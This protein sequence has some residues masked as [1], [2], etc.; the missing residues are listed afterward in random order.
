MSVVSTTIDRGF[1][2]KPPFGLGAV[3]DRGFQKMEAAQT[4]VTGPEIDAFIE[5]RPSVAGR[6]SRNQV[7]SAILDERKNPMGSIG[8]FK[9]SVRQR[10]G[11]ALE[12]VTRADVG[13]QLAG[14]LQ[15]GFWEGESAIAQAMA[16]FADFNFHPE[17]AEEMRQSSERML[18]Y[19]AKTQLGQVAARGGAVVGTGRLAVNIAPSAFAL[20]TSGGSS[21]PIL[22]YY[23]IQ[24]FGSGAQ[25]Y[26]ETMIARGLTPDA[27]DAFTV[28][29]GYGVIEIVA[30]KIGLDAMGKKVGPKLAKALGDKFLR[31]KAGQVTNILLQAEL[32]SQIEGVEELLTQFFQNAIAKKGIPFVV[33]G[34][35]PNRSL[36]ENLVSSY[37]LGN[38]GGKMLIGPA[39]LAGS[40]Q[41]PT[42]TVEEIEGL[43]PKDGPKITVLPPQRPPGAP[44]V[45]RPRVQATPSIK[46]ALKGMN[47]QDR[48]TSAEAALDVVTDPTAS[49]EAQAR[50]L[51]IIEE[52]DRREPK[53][54]EEDEGAAAAAAQAGEEAGEVAPTEAAE[55]ALTPVTFVGFQ[56]GLG[57]VPGFNMVNEPSGTTVKFDPAKHTVTGVD[58]AADEGTVVPK[59]LQPEPL[60]PEVSEPLTKEQQDVFDQDVESR[61]QQEIRLEEERKKDKADIA[62]TKPLFDEEPTDG[63]TPTQAKD[64]A[65]EEG[66]QE[67][68]AKAGRPKDS[69]IR[70]AFQKQLGI[71]GKRTV[72]RTPVEQ[73]ML[74]LSLATQAEVVKTFLPKIRAEVK[75]AEIAKRDIRQST[76][77]L[78]RRVVR[79]VVSTSRQGT[80]LRIV[81]NATPRQIVT[82]MD[83]IELA[84]VRD[85]FSAKANEI[86]K[87]T[88]SI[89]KAKIRND[90]K[91]NINALLSAATNAI[92]TKK[93]RR[94]DFK[95]GK[96]K[97]IPDQTE[98][99]K[100]AMKVAE[101][102]IEEAAT[103]LADRKAENLA[104]LKSRFKNRNIAVVALVQNILGRGRKQK[105]PPS[106]GLQEDNETSIFGKFKHGLA[107]VRNLAR[108]IETKADDTSILEQLMWRSM[109][110][111][112]EAHLSNVRDKLEQ[113]QQ[114]A[115]NAGLV[116]LGNAQ[117]K[118]SGH[119]GKGL[120]EE[121][122]VVIGGVSTKLTMG[123]ALWFVAIDQE[124]EALLIAGAPLQLARGKQ[125]EGVVMTE[126]ELQ[127][128]RDALPE[129]LVEF[130]EE[131]KRIHDQ[132]T[133][134]LM[135]TLFDL[136]GRQPRRVPNYFRRR[137]NLPFTEKAGLP[138]TFQGIVLQYLENL[139]FTRE[140]E[141]GIGAPI[142]I[143]DFLFSIT[144]QIQ[145]TSKVI[146]I[147]KPVRAAAGVLLDPRTVEAINATKGAGTE[148]NEAL[149]THLAGSSLALTKRG[150]L[151]RAVRFLNTNLAVG[152]LGLNP[153]SILRQLGGIPRL[154]AEIGEE[155][156]RDGIAGWM[157][158]TMEEMV[159]KSGYF[160]ERYIANPS[161]RF[162]GIEDTGEFGLD[163]A[164]LKLTMDRAAANFAAGDVKGAYFAL[165][166]AG[167]STLHILNFFDSINARI[168]WAGYKAEVERDHPDWNKARQDAWV[169]EHA[170]DAIRETQNSSSVLD[171]STVAVRARGEL[172]S[173]W[174][175]FSSDRIKT[176]NRI[177]RA[178]GKSAGDAAA[179]ISAEAMNMIWSVAVGRGTTLTVAMFMA[180]AMGDDDDR[181]EALKEA[182]RVDRLIGRFSSEA[183]AILDPLIAPRLFDML[184][185]HR[186]NLFD[187]AVGSSINDLA[188][189]AVDLGNSV[190]SLAEGDPDKAL[191]QALRGG[192]KIGME[193]LA[194]AG[195]DPLDAIM[196]RIF[197][198]YDDL[199]D[200]EKDGLI[201]TR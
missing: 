54:V 41:Q 171:L 4:K 101:P 117:A 21:A 68:A 97:S 66:R 190:I 149:Q 91:A 32:V 197:R 53:D 103:I 150:N 63:I 200:G 176:H 198:E 27:A 42:T 81:E 37:L 18:E 5:K 69:D 114:A 163:T 201:L 38:A 138:A 88:K 85:D 43:P 139:G 104:V 19:N 192:R 70:K 10:L 172:M 121:I 87:L 191:E 20:L 48:A 95:R 59:E 74:E 84:I 99:F 161:G 8:A 119:A 157:N 9:P 30:E 129:E 164:G 35:D 60:T 61:L 173:L 156:I 165:R 67:P 44:P 56:E 184:L 185:Y 128:V 141:G 50:A 153:S 160:W 100:A 130:V 49:P 58:P 177:R 111:A 196:Q 28:G 123:E 148:M 135:E 151:A 152:K 93:G 98:K 108:K 31:N 133:D 78:I 33:E 154:A 36:D 94:R 126:Q 170:A 194:L 182:V 124:T 110:R 12:D 147:A 199:S 55:A 193:A 71:S 159:S 40:R 116:S 77:R 120:L 7:R 23:G 142:I 137:R 109:T 127:D 162:S 2:Q 143:E 65:A 83:K 178:V 158:I 26:R 75:A 1:V 17:F 102:G 186:A 169:A 134:A 166:D 82:I 3:L 62:P 6:L 167:I 145:E 187:N 144:D 140:R 89:K 189:G 155:R 52:V 92:F 188:L 11:F 79:A 24:A 146:H 195:L 179:A 175:L 122:D 168:A 96:G 86:Q 125:R 46:Q 131:A 16:A 72:P 132:D 25:D 106:K 15:S 47:Q 22:A 13:E 180:L 80:F 64:Q 183:L 29:V 90:D 45:I 39:A 34:F 181:E 112:H 174:L 14:G 113:I 73:E 107:D 105:P 115:K 57:K 118:L 51:Q 76:R 136:K